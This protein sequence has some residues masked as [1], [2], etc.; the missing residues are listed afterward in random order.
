MVNGNEEDLPSSQMDNGK[1]MR[2]KDWRRLLYLYV[3]GRVDETTTQVCYKHA[4][5]MP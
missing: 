3:D 5:H 1:Q 2:Q 4:T